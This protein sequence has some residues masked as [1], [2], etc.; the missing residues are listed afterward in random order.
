MLMTSANRF[1]TTKRFAIL[2]S[3]LDDC[4]RLDE[5]HQQYANAMTCFLILK[6]LGQFIHITHRHKATW[7]A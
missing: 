1:I 2:F 6:H 5:R 3:L 4:Y 7:Q